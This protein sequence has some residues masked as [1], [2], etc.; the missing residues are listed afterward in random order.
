MRH[1]VVWFV[2]RTDGVVHTS[3]PQFKRYEAEQLAKA[4]GGKIEL[5]RL[6]RREFRQQLDTVVQTS[7]EVKDNDK[8]KQQR[9]ATIEQLL[10]LLD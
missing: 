4:L 1:L 3:F 2:R 5:K 7:T 8:K 10:S 6:T 9:E